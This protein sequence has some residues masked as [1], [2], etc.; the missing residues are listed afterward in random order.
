MEFIECLFNAMVAVVESLAGRAWVA[1]ALLLTASF[2]S[3]GPTRVAALATT[4]TASAAPATASGSAQLRA[5]LRPSAWLLVVT[6][7]ALLLPTL[8]WRRPARA[9]LRHSLRLQLVVE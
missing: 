5:W 1:L 7:A 3:R 2:A 4:G 8:R 9:A 6:V